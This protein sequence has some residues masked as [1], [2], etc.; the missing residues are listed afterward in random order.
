VQTAAVTVTTAG[1]GL[2]A[3]HLKALQFL[4]AAAV[5]GL[6]PNDVAVIDD[7]GGLLSDGDDN[8]VGLN[9][10]ERATR[11]RER[12]ERLLGARVGAGNAV[13]E[14]TVDAVTE[15]ESIIERRVDPDS[16]IAISTDVRESA[17]NSTDS[18]GGNVTVA[19][20]LPEGGDAGASRNENSESRTLTNYEVSQTER[21]LTKAPGAIKRLTVAVLVND[22]TTTAAD[23]T[24]TTTPRTQEELSALEELVASA[25]GLNTERGDILTLRSMAFQPVTPQGTEVLGPVNTTPLDVMQ[26]IQIGVLAAVTLILGLFVVRPILSSGAAQADPLVIEDQADQIDI[27]PPMAMAMDD[28]T[29]GDFMAGDM[30]G[31]G[32]DDAVSRLKSIIADREPETLQILQDW[33]DEP[34]TKA[35]V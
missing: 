27:S 12:A 5:P 23:G 25:V 21:Q 4:I 6:S 20:N 32:E 13:V 10:D 34:G 24:S 18:R 3:T 31:R 9:N 35:S 33:I 2:A 19:S 28:N 8:A 16:R 14:V 22:V 26:L 30:L 7:E 17:G 15:T 29:L 11:L 1:G